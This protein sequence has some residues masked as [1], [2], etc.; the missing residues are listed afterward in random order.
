MK[1]V[2]R[3]FALFIT[4]ATMASLTSCTKDNSVK[5]IGKWTFENVSGIITVS[6]PTYQAWLDAMMEEEI[7]E[8]QEEMRGMTMEFK[9][10]N[11]VV[12]TS[13]DHETNQSHTETSQYSVEGDQITIDGDAM[14]IKTLTGSSLILEVSD[15]FTEEGVTFTVVETVEFKR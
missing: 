14:T 9:S 7:E 4:I 10:D 3:V 8:M 2:L 11:T 15:S 6:D 13:I 1:K 5:I 12:M